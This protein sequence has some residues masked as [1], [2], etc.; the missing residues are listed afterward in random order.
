MDNES[1]R[2]RLDEAVKAS[3][4][5]RR[6]VS[7]GAGR[8]SNYLD[9]VLREGKDPTVDSLI[10]ICQELGVTTAYILHGVDIS[11]NALKLVDLLESA[12]PE[13]REI[14]LAVLNTRARK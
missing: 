9:S 13:M 5:S 14:A 10:R 6:S 12:D 4:R 1:W 7:M 2:I 3:G 11:P 8:G